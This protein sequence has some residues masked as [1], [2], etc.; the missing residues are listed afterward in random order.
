[1]TYDWDNIKTSNKNWRKCRTR[2]NCVKHNS[3]SLEHNQYICYN[4][5]KAFPQFNSFLNRVNEGDDLRLLGSTF[6]SYLALKY[7]I[8]SMS[9]RGRY[10]SLEN[11]K[12]SCI[13]Q[14][15]SRK[16]HSLF[17]EKDHEC[18]WILQLKWIFNGIFNGIKCFVNAWV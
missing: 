7:L 2:T 12:V 8:Q 10:V 15:C 16:L 14:I 9:V 5:N 3:Q 4:D 17:Q 13:I 11:I 6:Q 1:M 18:I